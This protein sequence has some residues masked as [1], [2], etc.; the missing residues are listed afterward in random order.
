MNRILRS[1]V[2]FV[3]LCLVA[4]GVGISVFAA[5]YDAERVAQAAGEQ[6]G[7][8]RGNIYFNKCVKGEVQTD[9]QGSF[10]ADPASEVL[11][12]LDLNGVVVVDVARGDSPLPGFPYPEEGEVCSFNLNLSAFGRGGRFLASGYFFAGT[13]ALGQPIAMTLEVANVP[14]FVRYELPP[15]YDPERIR[16]VLYQN[17]VRQGSVPYNWDLRGFQVYL[18][19]LVPGM[20]DITDLASGVELV[21]GQPIDPLRPGGAENRYSSLNVRLPAGVQVVTLGNFSF[22]EGVRFAGKVDRCPD[23]SEACDKKAPVPA[24]VFVIDLGGDGLAIWTDGLDNPRLEAR[25]WQERGV[26]PLI[27]AVADRYLEV[28][29]GESRFVV[30]VTGSAPKGFNIYFQRISLGGGGGKG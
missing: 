13:L 14:E 18:N 3:I 6:F 16:L 5:E 21:R 17:G 25:R 1:V 11:T 8:Y 15:G 23:G 27:G 10:R 22:V 29:K 2:V 19:P 4:T 20:Y 28:L 9:F 7:E 24:Q 26:M 12:Y 30:T